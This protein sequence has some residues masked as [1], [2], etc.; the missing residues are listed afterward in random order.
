MEVQNLYWTWNKSLSLKFC[1]DIIK[2]AKSKRKNRA[3]V[4]LDEGSKARRSNIIWL[5]DEKWI[6]RELQYYLKAANKKA[7]WNFDVNSAEA[8]QFTIYENNQYYDW[9]IDM[10]TEPKEKNTNRKISLTLCLSDSNEYEGGDLQ[11]HP[12][13][14]PN[15]EQKIITSENFRNKGSVVLFPSFVWHRVTPVTKG[16]RYSLVVWYNGPSFK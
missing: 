13:S 4:F 8:C 11:F 5:R 14:N 9:H 7:K 16:K 15:E 3:K 6:Y 10:F 1:D 12:D 2:F